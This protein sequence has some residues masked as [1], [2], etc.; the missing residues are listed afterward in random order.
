MFPQVRGR[1]LLSE[2]HVMDQSSKRNPS[3]R[4]G[5]GSVASPFAQLVASCIRLA[6]RIRPPSSIFSELHVPRYPRYCGAVPLLEAAS[7][8]D[9]RTTCPSASQRRR[10]L[11][12]SPA[13]P[14]QLPP[15]TNLGFFFL[16]PHPHPSVARPTQG[17]R[18]LQPRPEFPTCPLILPPINPICTGLRVP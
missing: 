18:S 4:K 7:P 11:F 1:F 15:P 12:G 9:A 13:Q 10:A 14:A 16:N 3:Q 6:D 8:E 2:L 5:S 17:S